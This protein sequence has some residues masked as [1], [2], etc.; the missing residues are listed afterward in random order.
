MALSTLA[1]T[2]AIALI[3]FVVVAGA[4]ALGVL[5]ALAA[6][7]KVVTP[8]KDNSTHEQTGYRTGYRADTG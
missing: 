3:T 6:V 4:V 7:V 5:I 1:A 8:R 2:V